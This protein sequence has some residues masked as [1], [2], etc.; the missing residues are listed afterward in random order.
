MLG[1]MAPV[2]DSRLVRDLRAQV[3]ARQVLDR[4]ADLAAYGF[5]AT[6]ASG[7]QRLPEVVVLPGSTAEVAGVVISLCRMRAVLASSPRRC[8]CT[9]TSRPAP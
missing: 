5:D 2:S 7:E 3:G 8:A 4:P 9:R 6:G 1:S